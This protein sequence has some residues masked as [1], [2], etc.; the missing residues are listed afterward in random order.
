MKKSPETTQLLVQRLSSVLGATVDVEARTIYLVGEVDDAMV[1]RFL[2]GFRLLDSVPGDI[3]VVLSS[4]GGSEHAGYTIYDA[5]RLSENRVIIDGFGVVQSIAS[6]ILQAG[7]V[8]RLS[9]ECRFMIHN[10]SMTITDT[11]GINEFLS[12]AKETQST[13][14]RYYVI[15]AERSSLSAKKIANLCRDETYMTAAQ[16]IANGFADCVISPK[17][18]KKEFKR[19]K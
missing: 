10:G 3:T 18:P 2:V 4:T 6:A 16:A 7:D 11:V 19:T 1:Y 15:L 9:P 13:A 14:S 17:R 5:I 8:R 12:L